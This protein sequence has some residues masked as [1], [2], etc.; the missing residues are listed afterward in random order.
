MNM[1]STP[2][3]VL[4][5]PVTVIIS[6]ACTLPKRSVVPPDIFNCRD[7]SSLAALADA[8]AE[9][10][11]IEA[12][13][14]RKATLADE[15]AAHAK[16]VERTLANHRS[17]EIA[18]LTNT[19]PDD[20]GSGSAPTDAKLGA[21]TGSAT[22]PVQRAPEKSKSAIDLSEFEPSTAPLDPWDAAEASSNTTSGGAGQGS[23][24]DWRQLQRIMMGH[25]APV[26]RLGSGSQLVGSSNSGVSASSTPLSHATTIPNA[27]ATPP[28]P[29]SVGASPHYH[30][31][32]GNGPAPG[33]S[34]T[35]PIPPRN[36]HQRLAAIERPASVN[37]P[38]MMPP[39]PSAYPAHAGA[40]YAAMQ[41]PG[42]VQVG[43]PAAPGSMA[44][45]APAPMPAPQLPTRSSTTSVP[46]TTTGGSNSPG[47]NR[48]PN[49]LPPPAPGAPGGGGARP[50]PRDL[51]PNH[52]GLFY[53]LLDM[54]FGQDAIELAIATF[55]D[56]TKRVTDF[57]L[58]FP[59]LPPLP[60]RRDVVTA[61]HTLYNAYHPKEPSATAVKDHLCAFT[62]LRDMG[63]AA[64][65][66][67][68]ALVVVKGNEQEALEMLMSSA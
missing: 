38:I 68:T 29:Q 55:A 62:R 44:M 2:N 43:G 49:K 57:C 39:A 35:P 33:T 34:I 6:A 23:D 27:G 26:A 51:P 59:S 32:A 14:R 37:G 50:V 66:V 48:R 61:L 5:A 19:G 53:S 46:V 65:A 17:A 24:E 4:P 60:P 28:P 13:A 36:P 20:T 15:D 12:Y 1:H 16:R 30:L 21:T 63:F 56:H 3:Y 54:G 8:S 58:L 11:L 7:L 41:M 47:T 9:K 18:A 67:A 45:P 25:Q 64:D 40:G 52:H 22:V 10:A 31:M 42:Y